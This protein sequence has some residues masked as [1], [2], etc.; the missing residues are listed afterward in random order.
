MWPAEGLLKRLMRSQGK[1]GRYPL[2]NEQ[3]ERLPMPQ[4]LSKTEKGGECGDVLKFEIR[5]FQFSG[6][7]LC[8]VGRVEVLVRKAVYSLE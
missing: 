6:E 3:H 7:L 2:L 1:E 4:A 5:N 8:F